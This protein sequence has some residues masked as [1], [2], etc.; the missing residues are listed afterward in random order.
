LILAVL[1]ERFIVFQSFGQRGRELITSEV[2]LHL[3]YIL[4]EKPKIAG[5]DLSSFEKLLESLVIKVSLYL[6]SALN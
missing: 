4:T 2:A 5:V 3:L 1:T 6:H